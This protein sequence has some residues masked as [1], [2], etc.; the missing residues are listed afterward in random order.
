MSVLKGRP[1]RRPDAKTRIS[2]RSALP[3]DATI[4]IATRVTNGQ[5]TRM[6]IVA[7]QQRISLEEAYRQAIENYLRTQ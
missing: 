6:K 3:D 2:S 5:H 4:T 1:P 7:A